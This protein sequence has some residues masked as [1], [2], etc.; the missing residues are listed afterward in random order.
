VRALLASILLSIPLALEAAEPTVTL[1]AVGDMRLDGP[2]HRVSHAKGWSAFAAPVKH[3]L[4]ADILFGNLECALTERGIKADKKFNFRAPPGNVAILKELGFDV[5]SLANNH[6]MDYGADGLRDTLTAL[7]SA[8][9]LAVGAGEN[10][11]EAA[12]PVF[13]GRNGLTIGFLALTSTLPESMW[14]GEETPG[15][16]YSDFK[17][18]PQWVA[19]AK[20]KCDVLIVSFH[21]GTE[22]DLDANKVQKA[23]FAK[24]FAS[25]ADVVIGHHPHVLQPLVTAKDA[26]GIYSIGNFLM[27]SP[28]PGTEWSVISR[29]HLSKKGVRAEFTP[30]V[31]SGDAV[32]P[33]AREARE[34]MNLSLDRHG[35]LSAHPDLFSV[36][37]EN[38]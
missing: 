34:Q 8:S 20:K 35:V 21:G 19:D 6:V 10:R 15:V 7:S 9:I 28:T 30:V 24:L 13:I 37:Q 1:V 25:G 32:R 2:V 36:S 31:I 26:W 29:L 11:R 27:V 18:F 17:R 22:L 12:A 4:H 5:V 3:L 33:G 38:K 23:V 14:A 16:A